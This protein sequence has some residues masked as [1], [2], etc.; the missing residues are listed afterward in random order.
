LK[1]KA[2]GF[3]QRLLD[4]RVRVSSVKICGQKSAAQ[5]TC[6][7][8]VAFV[9]VHIFLGQIGGI[10]HRV[11]LGEIQVDVQLKFLRRNGGA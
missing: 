11:R 7:R 3:F 1:T 4:F 9:E 2:A 6:I 8:H 10:H 5:R